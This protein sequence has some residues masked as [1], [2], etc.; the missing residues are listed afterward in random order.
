LLKKKRISAP[1]TVTVTE[2]IIFNI[3]RP[4]RGHVRLQQVKESLKSTAVGKSPIV[5]SK[6]VRSLCLC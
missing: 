5:L 1:V 2:I 6:L 3:V 4:S